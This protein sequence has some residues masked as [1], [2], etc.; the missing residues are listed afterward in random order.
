MS[1]HDTSERKLFESERAFR[2]LVQ[3]VTDYAIY[4]LDPSGI[5]SS[6]N[7]GASRIK[8]YDPADIIG[9]HF[10]VFYPP[11]DRDSG[12]PQR[13]LETAR[14]T[15]RFE[16]EGWRIR[17][18]GTRFFASVVIDAIVEDG[19]LVGF[20]KITRDI[21]E[22]LRARSAL[23]ES[24]THFRLLVSNVTDYALY[25][26]DPE[27]HITNWNLGGQRIK[28]YVP[29]EIVG[30][31]FSRFYTPADREAGRPARALQIARDKGRYEEEG[32]RVRKDGSFFWA[33]VVIDPIRNDHGELIGFAKIT[34]DIT[35]RREA[36]QKLERM[37]KQL[38]ESQKMD[39]LG[40]LTG[41]V[42]HDFNNI[43]MAV[44][45]HIR[46]VKRYSSDPRVHKAADG[47]EASIQ[48]GAA[49][50]RQLLSFARRQHVNPVLLNVSATV[51]SVQEVLETGLG[52]AVRLSLDIAEDV[53][54]VMADPA[55]FETALVNLVIN[56]RDAV[57]NGGEVRITADN[58]RIDGVGDVVCISVA[59]DGVGIPEDVLANVFDPFFTTKP[60]GK[61]TGLGLSQVHGFA[62]QAGGSVAIESRLGEGTKVTICL[63]R[64]EVKAVADTLDP[65]GESVA[66][67]LLVEDNPDVA[68]S[69]TLLLEELG[70]RV[71]WVT[72]AEA[73]LSEIENEGI[74]IVFSDIVMPGKMDGLG[75]ARH[76]RAQRPGM[77]I[78]LASGYSDAA[79]QGGVEF[80]IL[81]KPYEL[82]EL[83]R[84]LEHA[85]ERVGRAN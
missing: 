15:G 83:S 23:S 26:L 3:G 84:A 29:D 71:K 35:E 37:Q 1:G 58:R 21:T 75:L 10:S 65:V 59:D 11:E 50:T 77:P 85:S 72:D 67:V 43:L 62:N 51:A 20:A 16:A 64:G 19:E 12:L 25:M 36:Q 68:T 30:Q 27:G 56:A 70:Y 46:L 31:H 32:L 52:S 24:E 38:A 73:A 8:G 76:L 9:R 41:G 69:S 49:L 47:I 40:Q 7:T 57:P 80:P 14:R 22:R 42:A 17:K 53:W 4:M 18:D 2:L 79:R 44:T 33:S 78:V 5:V 74:D 63:P 6:W 39:A 55:E 61:G 60:V 66:T 54:P 45:G 34:R 81:R 13:A 28:G 48:R 82:H